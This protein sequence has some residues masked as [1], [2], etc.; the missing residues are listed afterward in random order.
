[1]VVPLCVPLVCV[2]ENEMLHESLLDS[3]MGLVKA[4][5]AASCAPVGPN[6]VTKSCGVPGLNGF[7][8]EGIE[9]DIALTIGEGVGVG[10]FGDLV[11]LVLGDGEG[12]G[13]PLQP[14]TKFSTTVCGL[15]SL[16]KAVMPGIGA[17]HGRAGAVYVTV[18][19]PGAAPKAYV[20]TFLPLTVN[21]I[22]TQLVL[23]TIGLASVVPA[24][25]AAPLL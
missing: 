6:A 14:C 18:M 23:M 24:A 2:D 15:A 20:F 22:P 12:P 1:M 9:S 25:T 3:T 7:G 10:G 8:V 21:F 4:V 19:V 17:A 13:E 11:G 5:P 16:S